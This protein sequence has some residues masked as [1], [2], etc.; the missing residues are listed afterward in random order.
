MELQYSYAWII[1]SIGL[2]NES[3]F[4]YYEDVDYCFRAK[5]M[6]SILDGHMIA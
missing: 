6:D 5:N 3:Y 2:L 1:N 4:L